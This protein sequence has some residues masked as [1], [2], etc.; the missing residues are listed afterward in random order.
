MLYTFSSSVSMDPWQ[1]IHWQLLE[2]PIRLDILQFSGHDSKRCDIYSL[3]V[4]A[5]KVSQRGLSEQGTTNGGCEQEGSID[6]YQ[7]WWFP[8]LRMIEI[9]KT[10]HIGPHEDYCFFYIIALFTMFKIIARIADNWSMLQ[11]TQLRGWS[12]E[13]YPTNPYSQQP[14]SCFQ[15]RND[16]STTRSEI[17]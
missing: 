12:Q 8:S 11:A 7:T 2:G 14:T 3:L 13:S 16:M 15:Q 5:G 4:A 1:K 10:I 17:S 6:T 9:I